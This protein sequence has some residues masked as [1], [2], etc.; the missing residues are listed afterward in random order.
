MILALTFLEQVFLHY[1]YILFL[2][3][4][5]EGPLKVLKLERTSKG[6]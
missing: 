5:I 6:K 4:K 3:A 2:L 1:I